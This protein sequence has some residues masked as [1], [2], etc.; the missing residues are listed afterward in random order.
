LKAEK[1]FIA[2]AVEKRKLV[3]GICLG[4]E[5]LADA[6]GARVHKSR[7]KEIGWYPVSLTEAAKN[8]R[9]FSRLP[10]A[11]TPFHWHEY[12]F[13]IPKGCNRVAE[14]EGCENQAFECEDGLI[15]LQFHIEP[16]T[17]DIMRVISHCGD[18]IGKGKY[19]QSPDEMLNDKFNLKELNFEMCL[20][21]EGLENIYRAG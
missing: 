14:S 9:V 12:T 15:G 5:L 7:Y 8:S 17:E 4:A 16:S 3:L 20:L 6:M 1:K 11:F 21:M 18:N 13:D 10:T 2:S 19:V